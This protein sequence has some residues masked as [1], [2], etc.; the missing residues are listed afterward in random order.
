MG[1]NRDKYSEF[2]FFS[3]WKAD[4]ISG[5]QGDQN[6]DTIDIQ[7]YNAVTVIANVYSMASA[8]AQGA[9]DK[10]LFLLEHGLASAA[11][12]SAWSLVPGSQLIHSV[13]GGYDSTGE[14]G[15]FLS[16]MSKTE[17][18]TTAPSGIIAAV[19]YKKDVTHRYLRVVVRNSDDASAAWA[20]AVA[21]LALPGDWPVNTP[22]NIT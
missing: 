17:M 9:G 14:T 11:G 1:G 4:L 16:L 18:N 2:S 12:V 8:G 10:I 13:Y 7:S 3:A 20:A 5:S 22:V 19:G 15:V 21:L 6:G